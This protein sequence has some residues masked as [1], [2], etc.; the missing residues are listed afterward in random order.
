MKVQREVWRRSVWIAAALGVLGALGACGE[1]SVS[2]I[3]G[4]GS[5]VERWDAG[6]TVEGE[7]FWVAGGMWRSE[8][9]SAATDVTR[10][11]GDGSVAFRAELQLPAKKYLAGAEVATVAGR[12]FV[13]GTHCQLGDE[14]DEPGGCG[15]G[16]SQAIYAISA[17]SSVEAIAP[18]EFAVP[19]LA[20]GAGLPS[21]R[22]LG[23]RE[24]ELIV[25]ETVDLDDAGRLTYKV[26]LFAVDARSERARNLDLPAG[27]ASAA[28]L[29][30][31]GSTVYAV[32]TKYPP[33]SGGLTTQIESFET[34]ALDPGG[35]W[36]KLSSVRPDGGLSAAEHTVL[37]TARDVLLMAPQASFDGTSAAGPRIYPLVEGGQP[38]DG[39]PLTPPGHPVWRAHMTDDRIV[40]TFVTIE[41]TLT[42][43]TERE[44]VVLTYA[45]GS[46]WTERGRFPI[47]EDRF[48]WFVELNG[49]LVKGNRL[50]AYQGTGPAEIEELRSE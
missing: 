34:V 19:G 49:K 46:G 50:A 47:A 6:V 40:Q 28:S 41:E 9:P 29:C 7:D 27:V 17:D 33:P 8:V 48:A 35:E 23:V 26:R 25:A 32:V 30:L 5:A 4:G 21:L 39:A 37:C 38:S 31:A 15:N 22:L 3:S 24:E 13:V 1:S 18:P 36:T 43:S 14:F 45:P 42:T 44:I 16:S 20:G 10:F 2:T 11:R 12:A